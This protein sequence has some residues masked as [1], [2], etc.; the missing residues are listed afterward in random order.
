MSSKWGKY[1]LVLFGEPVKVTPTYEETILGGTIGHRFK[2][3]VD[4]LQ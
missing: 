1:L 2:R 4:W 3:G